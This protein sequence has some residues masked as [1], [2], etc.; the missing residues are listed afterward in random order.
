MQRRIAY[1][2]SYN[3][4]GEKWVKICNIDEKYFCIDP[5]YWISNYGRVRGKKYLINPQPNVKSQIS[6]CMVREWVDGHKKMRLLNV[7]TLVG[8]AFLPN[9]KEG[10]EIMHLNGNLSDNRVSN[11][12]AVERCDRGKVVKEKIDRQKSAKKNPNPQPR[13]YYIVKKMATDGFVLG[14]FFNFEQLVRQGFNI[15][16]IKR[17]ANHKYSPNN[18]DV[19]KGFKWSV[20]KCFYKA[21]AEEAKRFLM[22]KR[23]GIRR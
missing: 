15:E 18:P 17:A 22:E 3:K 4:K 21:I 11:L 8:R 23:H 20:E 2:P 10:M 14:T 16:A 5:S 7:H 1:D 6:Q 12:V 13:Y 9:Y 19:Y